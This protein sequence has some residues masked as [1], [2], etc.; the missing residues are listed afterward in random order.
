[1]R[2]H[3]WVKADIAGIARNVL[4]GTAVLVAGTVGLVFAACIFA[5]YERQ[6]AL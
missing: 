4:N 3:L 6:D 1:M 2:E 5:I